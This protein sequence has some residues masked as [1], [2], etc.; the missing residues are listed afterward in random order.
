[1]DT[2]YCIKN[3]KYTISVRCYVSIKNCIDS[4]V[5]DEGL[6]LETHNES[7][8]A[9]FES[10]YSDIVVLN[11]NPSESDCSKKG[12]DKFMDKLKPILESQDSYSVRTEIESQQVS[13]RYGF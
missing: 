11:I 9:G 4:L 5:L 3:I 10:V 2:P 7:M 1:M 12:I 6:Y 8:S 13:N